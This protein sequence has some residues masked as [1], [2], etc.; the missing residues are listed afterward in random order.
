MSAFI[1]GHDHIDALLTFAIARKTLYYVAATGVTVEITLDNASAI[2]AILLQENERSVR[3]YDPDTP[4]D[5]LPG[6]DGERAD[7][8]AFRVFELCHQ[9]PREQIVVWVLKACDCFDY[10]ACETDDY[11]SSLACRIID[12]IHDTAV[13][14]LMGYDEAPWHISRHR[15]A[16]RI[17]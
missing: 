17:A 11:D 12:C 1:V 5:D 9:L 4:A 16:W 2:G 3:H 8:Y 7:N 10:Q 6:T 13:E 14:S 15:C